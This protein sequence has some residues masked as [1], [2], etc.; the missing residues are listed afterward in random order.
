MTQTMDPE[1]YSP[2]FILDQMR[3]R[4]R[5]EKTPDTLAHAERT[6]EVA[7]RLAVAH[8]EDPDRAELA[9]LVHDVADRY[10]DRELLGLAGHYGIPVTLTEAR[11][12]RLLHARVGAELLREAGVRDEELLDAVRE[13][14]TG[15]P[16]MSLLAKITFVAD[17]DRAVPRPPLWRARSHQP[18]GRDRSRCRA[19]AALRLADG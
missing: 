16:R 6:A 7:R 3:I 2:R 5:A 10:S 19:H 14:I 12:P 9:G 11:V 1:T 4:L 15:G 17:K 13:H 8:G 18:I